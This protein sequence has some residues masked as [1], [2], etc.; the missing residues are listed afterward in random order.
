MAD[1]ELS[2]RPPH[3]DEVEALAQLHARCW[4]QTYAHLLPPSFFDDLLRSRRDFWTSL[5]AR[6]P[7]PERLAV[8]D[9]HGRPVGLAL[10]GE[11]LGSDPARP[12]QLYLLYLD[13]DHHG[14]GAGQALLDAVVGDLPAQ[15]WVA[16]E[17]PRARAFYARNGFLPDGARHI[18]A[19]FHD[20]EELR[21]VR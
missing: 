13:A 4:R 16:V 19:E 10:A 15:L 1:A 21:L 3:T 12:L 9:K 2:I 11:P 18:D 6:D 7:L 5:L 8:A 17:N 14:S 20:L